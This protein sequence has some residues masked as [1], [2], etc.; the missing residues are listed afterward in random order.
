MGSGKGPLYQ[1][2]V[3]EKRTADYY[4]VIRK[5]INVYLPYFLCLHTNLQ[6]RVG[7]HQVVFAH[8]T[9][10]GC[11]APMTLMGYGNLYLFYLHLNNVLHS[12]YYDS[13]NIYT[14][15]ITYSESDG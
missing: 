4:L 5:K 14:L 6:E 8:D 9:P 7:L 10:H 15:H 11:G 13:Y 12:T 1:L 3:F 2:I